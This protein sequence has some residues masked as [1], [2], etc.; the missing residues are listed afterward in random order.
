MTQHGG[1]ENV[2]ALEK[3]FVINKYFACQVVYFE[4]RITSQ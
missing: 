2:V 1:K 3:Q 4:L